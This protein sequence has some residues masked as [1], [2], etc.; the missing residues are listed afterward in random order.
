MSNNK[1]FSTKVVLRLFCIHDTAQSK[2]HLN[3]ERQIVRTR[4]IQVGQVGYPL[5]RLGD[6]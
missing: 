4:Q 5:K 1:Q 6:L 2:I 3:F